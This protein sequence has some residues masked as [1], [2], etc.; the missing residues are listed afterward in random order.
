MIQRVFPNVIAND[1][2]ENR[3]GNFA[4]RKIHN[5]TSAAPFSN[6]GLSGV[7]DE[8]LLIYGS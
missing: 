8:F 7:E 3:S 6:K 2:L 5:A 4:R 1:T